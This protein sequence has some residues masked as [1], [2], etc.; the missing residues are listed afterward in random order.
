MYKSV[1]QQPVTETLCG[2]DAINSLTDS[3]FQHQ[4]HRYSHSSSYCRGVCLHVDTMEDA[5]MPS[6]RK[7][8]EIEDEDRP[9]D[10]QNKQPHVMRCWHTG[11]LARMGF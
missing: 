7:G 4:F 9:E 10:Y 11:E 8:F 2:N 3:H 1:K 6:A 5:E